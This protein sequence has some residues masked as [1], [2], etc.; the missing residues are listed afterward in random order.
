MLK[1]KKSIAFFL[2][3]II[4]VGFCA[5]CNSTNN[6]PD[7]VCELKNYVVKEASC[8]DNGII[9]S[10]CQICGK[11]TTLLTEKN[12]NHQ[13]V[14]TVEE[15]SSCKVFDKTV[16]KCSICN[17]TTEIDLETVG[18]HDFDWN[19]IESPNC[20]THNTNQ[21]TC[22]FCGKVANTDDPSFGPHKFVWT[23]QKIST[24]TED[25]IL[26]GD[27]E[28]CSETTTKSKDKHHEYMDGECVHCGKF[29]NVVLVEESSIV[30][31]S[32]KQI[33]EILKSF[34]LPNLNSEN[35]ALSILSST[36]ICSL[37]CNG[38]DLFVEFWHHTYRWP[39]YWF[40]YNNQNYYSLNLGA[41]KNDFVLQGGFTKTILSINVTRAIANND[42]M[43]EI[44]LSDGTKKEVG[45]L[46]TENQ[47][48]TNE[49][50][51]K[52]IAIN[53][54]NELLI[55]F[56]NNTVTK[57][58]TLSENKLYT[59]NSLLIYEKIVGQD[60]YAVCGVY[61][62]TLTEIVIPATHKGLP[63]IKISDYAF[64]YNSYITSV[65]MSDSI[66]TIGK[67]AF[68]NSSLE[69]I[70]IG[71]NVSVIGESAFCQ[72]KNLKTV[73][74]SDS[75][76]TIGAMAFYQNSSLTSITLGSNVSTIDSLAF[77]SCENLYKITFPASLK[78]IS[79]R[80]FES[81]PSLTII[82]SKVKKENVSIQNGNL[83]LVELDWTYIN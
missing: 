73:N 79:W 24:C 18:P 59:D 14:W 72:C 35:D 16:G 20:Q 11:K 41:L 38:D 28:L 21:G 62:T 53:K 12:N 31:Y 49:N 2:C 54:Q 55:F 64:N 44:V 32:L 3:T 40:G 51:I 7:H 81:T 37:Y 82:E 80:A 23:I 42:Y 68:S 57:C 75:V 45:Y 76:E 27:C 4:S 47:L 63:V 46:Y 19:L 1:I 67:Y 6:P 25:G 50:L 29:E 15:S 83:E 74:F 26:F 65:T 71:K 77:G 58:G 8:S 13:Y 69:A 61:D 60:A 36:S 22:T 78:T 43:L 70:T 33:T 30:G 39:D 34:N 9:E 48:V 66:Q 17:K 56:D 10:V 52:T 5:S